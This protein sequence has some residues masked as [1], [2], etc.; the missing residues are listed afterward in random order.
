MAVGFDIKFFFFFFVK[1]KLD[2]ALPI[3]ISRREAF[4]SGRTCGRVSGSLRY[5][6]WFLEGEGEGVLITR[7]LW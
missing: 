4:R 1:V 3:H 7:G 2:W 5:L 6:N